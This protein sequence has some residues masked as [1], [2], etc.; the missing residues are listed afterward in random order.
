MY[1]PI[2]LSVREFLPKKEEFL[3]VQRIDIS[4]EHAVHDF[5][6]V[7]RRYALP[8]AL[9]STG[10]ILLKGKCRNHIKSVVSKNRDQTATQIEFGEMSMIS[11]KVYLAI[12][13]YSKSSESLVAVSLYSN[14]TERHLKAHWVRIISYKKL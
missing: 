14:L 7:V 6:G 3:A 13:R 9:P 5:S 8:L 11:W 10:A 2:I 4:A 12:H 1:P